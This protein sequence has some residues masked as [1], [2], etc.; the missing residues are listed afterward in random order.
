MKMLTQVPGEASSVAVQLPY[1]ARY[2]VYTTSKPW[3][4]I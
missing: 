2:G 1:E 3:S 4:W